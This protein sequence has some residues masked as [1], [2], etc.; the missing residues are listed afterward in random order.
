MMNILDETMSLPDT[1]RAI[2]DRLDEAFS[3]SAGAP[4]CRVLQPLDM[5]VMLE[6]LSDV[7][8]RMEA[9]QEAV[10]VAASIRNRAANARRA[11]FH[12]VTTD[13]LTSNGR[14]A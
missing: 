8:D 1:V 9:V 2:A 6:R 3:A 12:V 10:A 14:S 11:C 7:A 13:V 5:L 4:D